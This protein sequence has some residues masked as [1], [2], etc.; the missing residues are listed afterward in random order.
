MIIKSLRHKVSSSE[1]SVNYVFDGMPQNQEEQWVIFQNIES[2]FDRN[3]ITNEFNENAHLLHK[4]LKRKK[5]I[6]YHEI[7]AFS[8]E[9]S[10]D[11]N[12][13]KLQ[14]I[15]QKYLKLRDP[16]NIAKAICVPHNE[17]HSHIHILL[18]S[19]AIGSPKSSDMMMTNAQYYDIRREMERWVLREY[20]ELHRSTVYLSKEEIDQLLPEKY[21]AERRLMEIEKPVKNKNSAKEQVSQ[22]VKKILER[23]HSLSDF[24]EQIN[25][26]KE[27]QTYSRRGKLTGLVHENKKK[28][29]FS[30]LGINLLEENFAVLSRMSE[31][32]NSKSKGSELSFER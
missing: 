27:F 21:R 7:L 2:G 17:K 29:R 25:K 16:K 8:H 23:S 18:T 26:T 5:T 12:R 9:N 4:N 1:Y 22:M 15:T 10:P 6:R 24:I 30:T 11:L 14:A 31:L 28:F 3:S 20:T 32:E 19:N 13:E